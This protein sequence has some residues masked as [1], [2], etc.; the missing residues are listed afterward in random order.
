M[1]IKDE[2]LELFLLLEK[3]N[4]VNAHDKCEDL[5]RIYKNDKNTR[6]ESFILKAFVNAI[7]FLEL[8][9]MQRYEHA[10]KIWQIFKKYENLIEEINS[11]NKIEYKKIQK[12]IYTKRENIKI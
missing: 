1:N 11:Q 3:N 4:F 6:E 9:K 2:L 12:L 7:A 5:W 8:I 10:K